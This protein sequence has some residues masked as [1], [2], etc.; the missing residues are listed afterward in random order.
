MIVQILV[1]QTESVDAL[2]QQLFHRVFDQPRIPMIPETLSQ[3]GAQTRPPLDLSQQQHPCIG[4]DL[5]TVEPRLHFA[6]R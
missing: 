3:S 2:P 1:P 5:S 4:G 6:L